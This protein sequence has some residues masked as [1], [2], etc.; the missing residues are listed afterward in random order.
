MGVIMFGSFNLTD[1]LFVGSGIAFRE[2]FLFAAGVTRLG[3]PPE[4][5]PWLPALMLALASAEACSAYTSL[6]LQAVFFR[7]HYAPW[8]IVLHVGV[9]GFLYPLLGVYLGRSL[10]RSLRQVHP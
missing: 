1:L 8:Y 2:V 6:V 3:P 10:G 7:L 5:P 4:R 9:A